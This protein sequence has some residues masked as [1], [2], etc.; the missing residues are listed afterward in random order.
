MSDLCEPWVEQMLDW[1]GIND[2]TPQRHPE[3]YYGQ[4]DHSMR[5]RMS[6]Q[7]GSDL[8]DIW[9]RIVEAIPSK[10]LRFQKSVIAFGFRKHLAETVRS[11]AASGGRVRYL[12]V[13]VRRGHSLA[14]VALAAAQALE[15]ADGVD[16]WA[17]DYGG[18]EQFGPELILQ[19]LNQ[20]GVDTT[21][22]TLLHTGD[23]HDVL[24]LMVDS[25]GT[26]NLIL[27]DG[28]H[29]AKGAAQDLADCWEM[30]EPGGTLV[31]DDLTVDLQRV[32][33]E[34]EEEN[35]GELART[36]EIYA[37]PVWAWIRRA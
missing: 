30:L 16:L 27:V 19:T 36:S 31:F 21:G 29:T 5:R 7:A 15:Y 10:H 17:P 12:E 13:G 34:F 2:R 11:I 22:V 33:H 25:G 35:S 14:F 1:H 32:W 6:E 4:H 23:S 9:R 28:D 18:E 37:T 8:N 20:L 26:Y 3:N 24:P